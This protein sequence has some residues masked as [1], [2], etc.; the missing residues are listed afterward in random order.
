MLGSWLE[1]CCCVA[2][3]CCIGE[4]ITVTVEGYKGTVVGYLQSIGG[5]TIFK[6]P[7]LSLSY[8]YS[9]NENP[10]VGPLGC[11]L[12]ASCGDIIHRQPQAYDGKF[13]LG[14]P[15]SP[16][17]KV[18]YEEIGVGGEF[19]TMQCRATAGERT[20]ELQC[21]PPFDPLSEVDTPVSVIPYGLVCE[22]WPYL[23]EKPPFDEETLACPSILIAEMS[24]PKLAKLRRGGGI[25]FEEDYNQ[26][27]VLRRPTARRKP[28]I[29]AE[30]T[31]SNPRKSTDTDAS[32]LYEVERHRNHNVVLGDPG[33]PYLGLA[34]V[35][36]VRGFSQEEFYVVDYRCHHRNIPNPVGDY[37]C[38]SD[39]GVA[40]PHLVA[41]SRQ[42]NDSAELRV[43][44][45]PNKFAPDKHTRSPADA[46]DGGEQYPFPIS[47]II[48]GV[49]IVSPG[50][51]YKVGD[52]FR[53]FFRED[54]LGGKSIRQYA[55]EAEGGGLQP[56]I[57]EDDL[58]LTVSAVDENGGITALT[59]PQN[60]ETPVEFFRLLCHARSVLHGGSGY[61]VGDVITFRAVG[62][63]VIEEETATAVVSD[64]DEN[65]AILDWYIKGSDQ[66]MNYWPTVTG[67]VVR[68]FPAINV[69]GQCNLCQCVPGI[70]P[71]E[72]GRYMWTAPDACGLSWTGAYAL[73][74][75]GGTQAAPNCTPF[76][77]GHA[78]AIEPLS[79]QTVVQALSFFNPYTHDIFNPP[80]LFRDN[81]LYR[82]GIMKLFPPFPPFAGSGL[83]AEVGI[84]EGGNESVIGG[85]VESINILDGGTGYAFEELAHVPPTLSPIPAGFEYM[86]E[87]ESTPLFSFQFSPIHGY[88]LPDLQYPDPRPNPPS[89]FYPVSP[90]RYGY[91]TVAQVNIEHG[92]SGFEVGYRFY[93]Y[94]EGAVPNSLDPDECPNGTYYSGNYGKI[95]ES[96]YLSLA[97]SPQDGF[98]VIEV[99]E[100]DE[101]TGEVT[102]IEIVDHGLF[103][104][105]HRTGNWVQH[106]LL[107]TKISSTTGYGAM[108]E[109]TVEETSAGE[110]T[111]ITLIEPPEWTI[112][113]PRHPNQKMPVGGR[114]YL[115][116]ESGLAYRLNFDTGMGSM[117]AG[118][119]FGLDP[120]EPDWARW[121]VIDGTLPPYLPMSDR[122]ATDDCFQSLFGRPHTL[123]S[124]WTGGFRGTAPGSSPDQFPYFHQ[125]GSLCHYEQGSGTG[126][127][128]NPWVVLRW[129]FL[130]LGSENNTEYRTI[131]Y[132]MTVTVQDPTSTVNCG[133]WGDKNTIG[134]SF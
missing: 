79:A 56:Y 69:E 127:I 96:G 101:E 117:L 18:T 9:A 55:Q 1:P 19:N 13:V 88:P 48:S 12:G 11:G 3:K 91:F 95:D 66:W 33:V 67:D 93:F 31:R 108:C 120:W 36:S 80:D 51:E 110:I 60:T 49:E 133:H 126:T 90:T 24:V 65:G 59:L 123:F 57:N 22:T 32:L 94:P 42:S 4:T 5:G 116:T 106:P 21:F 7:L 37:T 2:I 89:E 15:T 82:P 78:V 40:K 74:A 84:L 111:A 105:V 58:N 16:C 63:E 119:Y 124:M 102:G 92:G 38:N 118:N 100:V 98:L 129:Q 130:F 86:A 26:T 29:I 34:E 75:A 61:A 6:P 128:A 53:V 99:T 62:F 131:E 104:K 114:D 45:R 87:E 50:S 14:W 81:A 30:I 64:V 10:W 122:I 76:I 103:Y 17:A 121:Q 70:E 71:D 107:Y 35:W 23:C 77:Q 83:T 109:P 47:W 39:I 28:Q 125:P 43:F 27:Y 68:E 52:T 25:R 44:S 20:G 85:S 8:E 72:R 97:A 115:D 112:D 54:A 132:G 46:T 113:D 73:R 134:P 41:T